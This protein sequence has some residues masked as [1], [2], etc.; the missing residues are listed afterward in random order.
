[1]KASILNF[2]RGLAFIALVASPVMAT[3]SPQVVSAACDD[4]ILGIPPWYR[5]LTTGSG[6]SCTIKSPTEV[7]GLS[8]FVWIIVLNGVDMMISLTAY[9][10][11]GF[12]LFGGFLYM[13]GG[14]IPSQLER[15]RKTIINA[16][17]G[18]VIC[19]GS[20][21][22]LNLIFGIIT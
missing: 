9:V 4:R 5:G 20:I 6:K 12:I 13:T 22:L 17:V 10:T 7:G 18:L 16:V 15:A 14:A 2:F 3:V 8:K 19:M 21:A 1:M 11:V